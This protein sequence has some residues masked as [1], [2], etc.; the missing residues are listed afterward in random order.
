MSVMNDDVVLELL[1]QLV[2][3]LVSEFLDRCGTMETGGDK[4]SDF[5]LGAALTEFADHIGK[6]I[7]AGN[8]SR[9]ITDDN[10]TVVFSFCQFA[11]PWTVDRVFHCL[12]HDLNP[13][14]VTGKLIDIAGQDGCIVRYLQILGGMCI[15]EFDCFHKILCVSPF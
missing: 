12:A 10:D 11:E 1:I 15:K 8:R 14:P 4:Q 2:A 5:D 6:N 7:L 3:E 9:V 13:G